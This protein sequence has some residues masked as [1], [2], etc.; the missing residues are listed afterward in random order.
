MGLPAGTTKRAVPDASVCVT[1]T[2]SRRARGEKPPAI[3]TALS[4]VMF[5]TYGYCPGAATSPRMKNGRYA[6]ISTATDGSLIKPARSFAD[7]AAASRGPLK[8][9]APLFPQS[10]PRRPARGAPARRYRADQRHRDRAARA[11]RIGI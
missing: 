3:A 6:S 9:P 2:L 7:I 1:V 11:D 8:N 4:T 5:G 10:P